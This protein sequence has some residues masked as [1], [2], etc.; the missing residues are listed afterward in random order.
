MWSA[1]AGASTPDCS[2]D[3]AHS[4]DT[5]TVFDPVVESLSLVSESRPT[6]SARRNMARNGPCEGATTPHLIRG[7]PLNHRLPATIMGGVGRR[8]VTAGDYHG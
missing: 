2:R 6:S 8:A 5:T 4:V 7:E 3:S 1:N